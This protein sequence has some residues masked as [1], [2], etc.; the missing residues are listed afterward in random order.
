[1]TWSLKFGK[2]LSYPF[3]DA[4]LFLLVLGL[5]PHPISILTEGGDGPHFLNWDLN[6]EKDI[7]LLSSF[8]L[9][10]YPNNNL[11]NGWHGS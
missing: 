1:M 8:S 10:F 11:A 2:A 4:F 3:A 7:V 9:P 5:F 6:K